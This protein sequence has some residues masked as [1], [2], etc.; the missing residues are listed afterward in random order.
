[1]DVATNEN[2]RALAYSIAQRNV[3]ERL[4]SMGGVVIVDDDEPRDANKEQ[5]DR[6]SRVRRQEKACTF[7]LK[8]PQAAPLKNEAVPTGHVSIHTP[9]YIT[10]AANS[11]SRSSMEKLQRVVITG[12]TSILHRK[13]F[14]LPLNAHKAVNLQVVVA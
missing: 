7:P 10:Y 4:A 5:K 2:M 11:Q 13:L 9:P 1:M 14:F 6:T 8:V 3:A 12:S